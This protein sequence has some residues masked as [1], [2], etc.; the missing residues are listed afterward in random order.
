M[1]AL[2]VG[3]GGVGGGRIDQRERV[4]PTVRGASPLPGSGPRNA[5]ELSRLALRPIRGA[6]SPAPMAADREAAEAECKL[7]LERAI[8]SESP[9]SPSCR[10]PVDLDAA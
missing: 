10:R 8:R 3:L 6:G 9:R 1:R 5:C 7:G 4:R 2:E